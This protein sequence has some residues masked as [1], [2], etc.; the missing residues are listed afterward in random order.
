VC[1]PDIT[2]VAIKESPVIASGAPAEY[3]RTADGVVNDIT[4]S[5]ANATRGSAF[6]FQRL[7]ALLGF[8]QSRVGIDDGRPIR[9]PQRTTAVLGKFDAAVNEANRFSGWWNRGSAGCP[10]PALRPTALSGRAASSDWPGWS[11]GWPE[12]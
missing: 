2:L 11:S 3:G 5:G 6:Y 8:L 10:N 4:K 12:S 9:Y 7:E 1:R